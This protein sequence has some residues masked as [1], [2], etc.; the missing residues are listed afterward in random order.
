MDITFG[1]QAGCLR[2]HNESPSNFE[3]PSITI[4]EII[5]LREVIEKG[6]SK[7]VE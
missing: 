5:A 1:V 4:L 6:M 3:A 2:K 7:S